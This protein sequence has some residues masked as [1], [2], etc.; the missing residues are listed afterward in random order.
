M[1]TRNGRTEAAAKRAIVSYEADG[2]LAGLHIDAW[3]VWHDMLKHIAEPHGAHP[4][5]RAAWHLPSGSAST[6]V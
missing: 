2:H 6:V 5:Y 4:D 3:G 1:T